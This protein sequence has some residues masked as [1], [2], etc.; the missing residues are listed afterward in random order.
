MNT[1]HIGVYG[2]SA[3]AVA[4]IA[5]S[6]PNHV[7]EVIASQVFIMDVGAIAAF[8]TW[9]KIEKNLNMGKINEI[10]KLL[11]GG[12]DLLKEARKLRDSKP[13]EP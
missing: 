4:M 8:T 6:Y 1:R 2:L 13:S 7:T 12:Q 3:I 11:S 9:D 5:A 10:S